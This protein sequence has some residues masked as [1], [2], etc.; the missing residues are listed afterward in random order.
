MAKRGKTAKQKNK[1]LMR[2]IYLAVIIGIVAVFAIVTLE[3]IISILKDAFAG[4]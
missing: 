2:G 3:S 1:A 4:S